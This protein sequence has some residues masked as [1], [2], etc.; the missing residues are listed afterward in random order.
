MSVSARRWAVNGDSWRA[1]LAQLRVPAGLAL[2]LWLLLMVFIPI[3]HWTNGLA[4]VRQLVVYSVILQ[5]LAVFFILQA[6]WGWWRTLITLLATAGLTLFIEMAGTHTGWLFGAYHYTDHLQPQIGNVPLLIPLAWFMMLPPAWAVAERFRAR[7]WLFAA[8][9][10]GAM[11]AWDLFLDPQMVG[12]DLWRWDQ[13]GGYF[14]IPWHNYLGWF[15][16]AF[17]LTL[18]LR[19]AQLP[20]KPLLGIYA[21]TWFLETFGLLF[22][23]G[24]PG[25]ALVGSLVMGA[26]LVIGIRETR[27]AATDKRPASRSL[28]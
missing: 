25:P 26:F 16:T 28:C 8:V 4:A 14:G 27:G 20:R 18:L 6:A 22:F 17:L 24:L 13:P 1:S 15:A 21:I 19:P 9:A 2:S 12:W 10:A 7:P 11:T 3:S 23:W 5:S